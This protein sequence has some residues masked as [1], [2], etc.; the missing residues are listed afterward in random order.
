MKKTYCINPIIFTVIILFLATDC[1]K[2]DPLTY[3]SGVPIASTTYATISSLTGATLFGHVNA[4]G[5]STNVT[6]EYGTTTN[7]DNTVTAYQSPLE[8]TYLQHVSADISGLTTLMT[9]H[10]RV[11]AENSFGTVYGSNEEFIC[12]CPPTATALD[13][14]NITC[15]SATL[16]GNVN[17]YSASTVVTFQYGKTI[18]YEY[19]VVSIQSPVGGNNYTNVSAQISGLIKSTTYHFR[20]KA[21]NPFWTSYSSDKTINTRFFPELTTTSVS[22]ISANT[23]KSGGNIT[24]D[25]CQVQVYEEGVYWSEGTL[26]PDRNGDTNPPLYSTSN[27]SGKASFTSTLTGLKPSTT[28]NVRS[29]ARLSRAEIFG[30]IISFKTTR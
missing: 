30:K 17:A 3:T 18:D 27:G 5:L 7:Y 14:T 12:G 26:P 6:F 23:A 9:Y 11:K 28:Y 8:G 22:E 19:E 21:S 4:N 16:N 20:I 10:F 25:G 2:S 29:Y 13:A 15:A 1:K 24:F